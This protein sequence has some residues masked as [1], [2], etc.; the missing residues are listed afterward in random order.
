MQLEQPHIFTSIPNKPGAY[1]PNTIHFC[2][3]SCILLQQRPQNLIWKAYFHPQSPVHENKQFLK[4][5]EVM[6]K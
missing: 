1:T 5:T 2:F 6:Q 4:S 3:P